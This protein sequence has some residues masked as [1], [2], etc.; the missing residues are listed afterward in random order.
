MT[1]G[2]KIY[3][4]RKQKGFTQEKIA[5]LVGVSRQAIYKWEND[6]VQPSS[7]NLVALSNVLGVSTFELCSSI[8]S[9]TEK[10]SINQ[11]S[12]L[13]IDEKVD[14]EVVIAK[15]EE[16]KDKFGRHG[17]KIAII[18][19]ILLLISISVTTCMGFIIYVPQEGDLM[20]INY[21]VERI[22]FIVS[23]IISIVLVVID[24]I[25][26]WIVARNKKKQRNRTD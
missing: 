3:T 18:L 2:E 9:S 22:S 23:A 5:E 7:E 12:I 20:E 6:I 8:Y 17:V 15:Q 24:G 13:I 21:S 4:L 14:S 26:I 19:G 11:E 25:I 10:T 1:L 16:D